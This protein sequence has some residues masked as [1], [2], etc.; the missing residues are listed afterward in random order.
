MNVTNLMNINEVIIYAYLFHSY[1]G[2]ADCQPFVGT[3]RPNLLAR[4]CRP[5]VVFYDHHP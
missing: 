3:E 5:R 2:I 4:D 1:Q